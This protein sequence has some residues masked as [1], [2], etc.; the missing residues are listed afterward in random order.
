MRWQDDPVVE[1]AGPSPVSG[2]MASDPELPTQ[3]QPGRPSTPEPSMGDVAINAI[4]KGVANLLNTPET[5]KHLLAL[6]LN[7][8]PGSSV[9]PGIKTMAENPTNTPMDAMTKMGLVDPAKN[10]QTGSQRIVDMAIQ[11]AVGSAAIPGGGVLKSAVTGAVSGAAAQT[12]KE[13]TGSDLLAIAVGM[14]TPF[15]IKAL[16]DSA[17]QILVSGTRKQTLQDAQAAGYVVEPS[18]VR[19]PSSKLEAIA[20]KASIAQESAIRNQQVTNN[21]AAKTIGL[22]EDTP[23]T[24]GVIEDLRKEAGAVYKEVADVSPTAAKALGQ[25]QQARYDASDYFRYYNRTGDPK[26]GK[27]ARAF[28]AKA[29]DLEKLI[30]GEAQKIVEV[31]GAKAAGAAPSSSTSAVGFATPS[32]AG[33]AAT[34][35]AST[36]NLEKIGET[37]AGAPD[38]MAR[39]KAARTLIARTHDVERALNL[40]SGNVSAPIL[41]RM[42]DQGRPLTGEL[43]LVGRFAQAF[44]RVAR[45]VEAVPPSG[46]SGHDAASSAILSV[47]GAAAAGSPAGM[48]AGGAPLLRGPARNTVLS[49]KYQKGLLAEPKPPTPISTAAGQA[50]IAVTTQAANEP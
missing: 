23:L 32:T 35:S 47:G 41:G 44:P 6:G 22:P 18:S 43:S 48:V 45:E 46:V 15:A 50:G 29:D 26:A 37:T 21:L 27:M 4:A 34:E 19:A 49:P 24:M 3:A 5:L 1:Q 7:Q 36:I 8:I 12:T 38:L 9:V 13:V 14:G 28:Q 2:G 10:P 17:K 42:F 25:L 11:T 30:E 31:Y 40:G 20:G 39:L 16:T 33:P